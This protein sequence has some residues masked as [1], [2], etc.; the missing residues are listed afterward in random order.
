MMLY[1]EFTDT[2]EMLVQ[3]GPVDARNSNQNT[4]IILA[5]V[6]GFQSTKVYDEN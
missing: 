3:R 2:L 6:K 5:T 1:F 4:A